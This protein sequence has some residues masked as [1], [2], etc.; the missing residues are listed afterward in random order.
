MSR[1]FKVG[2]RIFTILLIII[3]GGGGSYYLFVTKPEPKKRDRPQ[4]IV[5][6]EL[7]DIQKQNY[8]GR[9]K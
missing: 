3:I 7:L 9:D 5:N 1:N 2:V 6:V 4:P 8:H